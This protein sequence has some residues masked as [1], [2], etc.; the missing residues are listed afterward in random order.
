MKRILRSDW[1]PASVQD[2]PIL[3]A[4]DFPSRSRKEKLSLWPCNKPFIDQVAFF[5]FLLT[6]TSPRP[7]KMQKRT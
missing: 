7:I 5:A 6:S 4:R 3:P 2:G 1:L